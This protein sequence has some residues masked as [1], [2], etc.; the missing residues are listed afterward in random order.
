MKEEIRWQWRIRWC[1]RWT[2][3]HHC[4]EEA[5]RREHPEAVR[6]E[7]SRQVLLVP[8]TPEEIA[9]AMYGRTP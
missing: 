1:G 3:S 2:T 7:G 8:S 9:Q 6:I 5:V 4:T